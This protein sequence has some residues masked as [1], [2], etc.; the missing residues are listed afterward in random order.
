[1]RPT[2]IFR[3]FLHLGNNE[4]YGT[5]ALTASVNMYA[6]TSE[7]KPPAA[8]KWSTLSDLN[9]ANRESLSTSGSMATKP[10]YRVET[11]RRYRIKNTGD[12][13]STQMDVDINALTDDTMEKAYCFGKSLVQVTR[14]EE[15]ALVLPTSP[16]M[17]IHGFYKKS[18]VSINY[19]YIYKFD[20]LIIVF[21]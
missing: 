8:K 17:W 9:L 7:V 12:I 3:G 10:S 5:R 20:N 6:Y 1:M 18:A 16:G 21:F 15:D 2:P 11:E 13:S 4:T 14:E 19:H